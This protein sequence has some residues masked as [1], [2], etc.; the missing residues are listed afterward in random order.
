ME[1]HSYFNIRKILFWNF[2]EEHDK[3]FDQHNFFEDT[4]LFLKGMSVVS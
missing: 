3:K 2:E 4:N 1:K